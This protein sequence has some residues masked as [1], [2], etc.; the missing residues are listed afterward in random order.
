VC[1][2]F[3]M[4][5][6][7]PLNIA[8]RF[9]SKRTLISTISGAVAG[10]ATGVFL[11]KVNNFMGFSIVFIFGALFGVGDIVSYF[12]V[13]H[14]PVKKSET[15]VSLRKIIADPFKNKRYMQL[16]IFATIFAFGMNFS[17]PFF[18]VYML[19]NLKMN[20]FMITLSGQIMSSIATIVVV[21][22][23]GSLCDKFGYKS[24]VRISG[25][26][27]VLCP[28]LWLL[29]TPSHLAMVFV[30]NI[31]SGITWS[32]YN[33]AIFNQSVWLAPKRNRSAYIACFT[34]LTSVVGTAA[35]YV[36]GGYFMQYA[37]PLINAMHI[38]F[39]MNH[40]LNSFQV[41]FILSA[42]IRLVAVLVF[43]PMVYEEGAKSTRELLHGIYDSFME[44]FI[45][46]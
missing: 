10:I 19:E 14:P 3:W 40:T 25:F 45:K 9:F 42:M 11:D 33:I 28:I 37:G 41:L 34:M 6:M 21:Q 23:W 4:G 18:N 36:A 20:Y 26:G 29:V 17:G 8:G 7:V 30:A 24:V 32:G 13:K 38:P 1:F 46:T 22:K 35:A 12:M 15:N 16:V 31:V 39:L 5:D 2:N 43:L 44:S 27:V